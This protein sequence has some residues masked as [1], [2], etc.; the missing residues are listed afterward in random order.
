MEIQHFFDQATSTLTYVVYDG[1]SRD[2][3]IID[4]VLDFDPASVRTSG[5]SV[6]LLINFVR[7]KQ[8]RVRL[9]LETHAHA[10]HLS[11]AL[12]LVQN[13]WPEAKIG[14][15]EKITLVQDT[16]KKIFNLP[17][18][19][20]TDGSQFH[21]LLRDHQLVTAG[22]L[23]FEVLFTP[24]HTPACA[25]YLFGDA[26]FVGDSLFMP[27]Y[28]TGRCDFPMGDAAV[29]FQSVTKR[30]YGQPDSTRIFVGHDYQ[31]GGRALKFETTVAASKAQNIHIKSDTSQADFIKFRT[32]RDAT[33]SAPRL[34]YPS[35]QVNIAAG[36]FLPPED[37]GK[38]YIKLPVT[39]GHS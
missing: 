17:A 11:S 9:I 36:Q 13:Y 27:D 6:A 18:D 35:V 28:G 14:I 38:T 8:L 19:F 2:A 32:T 37:N 30:I 4:P 7:E 29:L 24:G 16:F 20:K 3:V 10:D 21:S 12:V 22:T 33:L 26:L 34:L 31:P 15:G 23:R 1:S 5:Q 25:S 39:F